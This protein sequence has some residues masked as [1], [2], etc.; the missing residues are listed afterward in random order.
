MDGDIKSHPALISVFAARV[1]LEKKGGEL[2]AVCPF[3]PDKNPSLSIG[4]DNKGEWTFN[5]FGC[6]KSGDAIRFVELFD[7]VPFKK[8]KEAIEEV[9]GGDWE[10]SK[11]LADQTFKTLELGEAKPKTRYKLEEYAKFE[12]ALYESSEAKEWLFRERGITYD[13]ARALHFGFC[14]SLS[15]INRKYSDDLND[16]ADGGWIITPAVEGNDVVCIELRS[17]V[18]KEFSRKT[19]METKT[20]FGVDYVS[21]SE[22]IYVVEGKFDQAVL[23]QAGFRAISLPNASVKITPPMRDLLMSASLIILAGD[24]D[25]SV[26][27]DRMN[28]MWMEFKERTYKLVWPNGLKDA[29]E[30]FLKES[31]RDVNAFRDLV[32]SLTLQSYGTP[33]PGIESIAEILRNDDSVSSAERTDRF[34]F[35]LPAVD[36]MAIILPGSVVY[37]SADRTSSGKTQFT[38]QETIKASMYHGEVVI[39][40]QCELGNAEVAEI[41][42][43]NI[44]AKD[45]GEITKADRL[46]AARRLKDAQYYVGSNPDLNTTEAVLDL[47]EAGVRRVGATVVVLDHIHFICQNAANEIQAQ[48]QAMQRIKRMAQKYQLKFFVIGQPRKPGQKSSGNIDIYDAKGSESIVSS[49]DVVYLLSRKKLK[50]VNEGTHDDLS[51]E[52]EVRCVKARNRGKGAMFAK[53]FFLGKIATFNEISYAEEPEMDTRFEF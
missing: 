22:P 28:K 10:D 35:S 27:T 21:P 4:K 20:L 41:V 11:K 25:N 29:N 6:G 8:A 43:A 48:S 24:N 9:T 15:A 31:K 32:D 17:M 33:L 1:K 37:L 50:V 47:I 19:G 39:N 51:P 49:S 38:T 52:V 46:D 45:R 12:L 44:L 42:T 34:R 26:G 5:C 7:K 23:L 16:I 36:S 30:T 3:H 18:R 53:L 14:Q 2:W 13:T 40:Y